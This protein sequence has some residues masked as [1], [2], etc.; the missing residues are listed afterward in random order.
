MNQKSP[1][2]PIAMYGSVFDYYLSLGY[3][4]MRQNLFTTDEYFD[5]DEL[6]MYD[7]FWLRTKVKELADPSLHKI[8]KLNKD[9]EVKISKAKFNS[10]LDNLYE[11]YRKHMKF[12]AHESIHHFLIGQEKHCDFNAGIIEIRHQKEL[13]AAGYFDLGAE[14]ITGNLNFYNPNYKKYSL[15]KF[16]MLLKIKYA[17]ELN[18]TYYYTG[19]LAIDNAKFDY[20]LFPSI[21]A[22]EVLIKQEN[23]TWFPFHLIQKNGLKPYAIWANNKGYDNDITF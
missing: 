21:E 9:F 13:I 10:E 3:Y 4:R 17:Q 1:E 5:T 23:N 7:T 14:S 22:V 15:G 6:C 11:T 19:Y 16:L 8:W 12:D 2:Q 18:L 20:K